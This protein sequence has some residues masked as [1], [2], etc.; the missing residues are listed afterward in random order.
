MAEIRHVVMMSWK[1][2]TPD[3]TLQD[4]IEQYQNLPK[5]IPTMKHFEYGG[6]GGVSERAEG[7]SHCFIS[8]FDNLDDVRD[9]GPHP[10]HQAFVKA[11]EPYL[12]KIL[13]FDFE[14]K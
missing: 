14:V 8:T 11:I 5:S 4:L 12:E 10:A 3:A 2:G 7:F 6:E 1:A 9:Y 13:V